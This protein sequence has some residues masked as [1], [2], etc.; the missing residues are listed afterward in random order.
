MKQ[1]ELA[2]R[3]GKNLKNV[4]RIIKG[5]EPITQKTAIQLE[6]VLG[7]PATFWL[8]R[9]REFRQE[10]AQ[11]EADESLAHHIGWLA[12]FPIRTMQQLGWIAKSQDKSEIVKHLLTFFGIASPQQWEEIYLTNSL[13]VSFRMSLTHTSNPGA[14]SA[15]LRRGELE[16]QTLRLGPYDKK[17]FRGVLQKALPIVRDQPHDF[18]QQLQ[19]LCAQA[20]VAAVFT[21]CLPKAPISGAS[22]W[23]A[24]RSVPLIQLSGRYGINDAFWF[25]FFHEAAHILK[26]SKKDVFLEDVKGAKVD[27]K[28][29]READT[30]AS[31]FLFPSSAFRMLL[32]E[33]VD[34]DVI[35]SYA[36]QFQTHPA[37]IA[38]RLEHKGMVHQ[39]KFRHLKVPVSV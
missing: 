13:A 19:K 33:H 16:T 24:N 1:P 17:R 18:K 7:I 26:H 27:R 29:E 10:L 32:R 5:R 37:I 36:D 2:E 23:I 11:I 25:T 38:G 6:R 28:K 39:S 21:P 9:E 15:W 34:E 12:R 30:F 8:E 31:E 22:R 20:G 4:N 35:R 3:M 14:M